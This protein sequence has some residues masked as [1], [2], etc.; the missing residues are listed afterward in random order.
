MAL[1]RVHCQHGIWYRPIGHVLA[2]CVTIQSRLQ[3]ALLLSACPHYISEVVLTHVF[4]GLQIEVS[5]V[6][7]IECILAI[8]KELWLHDAW[9]IIEYIWSFSVQI[10]RALK[11][12]CWKLDIWLWNLEIRSWL[13]Q[14]G[15]V[16]WVLCLI[17]LG[18]KQTIKFLATWCSAQG[19][20][21]MDGETAVL[22]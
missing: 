10:W 13:L 17:F 18:A 11:K 5:E 22:H 16:P 4:S 8:P 9:S 6:P 7:R 14:E 12:P 1:Y 15:W 2:A 21:H 19:T 3:K 20:V